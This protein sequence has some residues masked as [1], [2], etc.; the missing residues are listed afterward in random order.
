M[1]SLTPATR[2]RTTR[3]SRSACAAKNALTWS[4]RSAV[5]VTARPPGCSLGS[6]DPGARRAALCSPE[7]ER[8]S[9]MRAPGGRRTSSLDL[10]RCQRLCLGALRTRER[11][12]RGC[13]LAAPRDPLPDRWAR[14]RRVARDEHPRARRSDRRDAGRATTGRAAARVVGGACLQC[15][16]VRRSPRAVCRQAAPGS[17]AASKTTTATHATAPFADEAVY[18]SCLTGR[19]CRPR[20]LGRPRVCAELVVKRSC[21]TDPNRVLESS[22]KPAQSDSGCTRETHGV[23]CARSVIMNRA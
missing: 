4:R 17:T 23:A 10:V 3:R 2:P 15:T 9:G 18:A 22:A 1:P 11:G 16:T 19:R 6:A 14:I 7:A 20:C 21:M 13:P 12:Q 8:R 5:P